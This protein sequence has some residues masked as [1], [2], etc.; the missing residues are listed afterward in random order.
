MAAKKDSKP[1]GSGESPDYPAS[2]F[3]KY[4]TGSSVSLEETYR[5]RE[6]Q[7]LERLRAATAEFSGGAYDPVQGV[8]GHSMRMSDL[9]AWK[10]KGG[11]T[12]GSDAVMRILGR[13]AYR[14]KL[15]RDAGDDAPAEITARD[16]LHAALESPDK[17][18]FEGPPSGSF[19]ELVQPFVKRQTFRAI[20]SNEM[21]RWDPPD[22]AARSEI[23]RWDAV[24][25][26]GEAA[27]LRYVTESNLQ[28]IST[29]ALVVGAFFSRAGQAALRE[30][31]VFDSGYERVRDA[32]AAAIRRMSYMDVSPWNAV[33]TELSAQPP[34]APTET[35]IRRPEYSPDVV[36]L[37][38]GDPL[39]SEEDA[40]AL[41]ELMLL[42]S[43][44]PP[45]A[46]G[47]FGAWGSGKTTLMRRIQRMVRDLT[48]DENGAAGGAGGS[49]SGLIKGVVQIEFNA[50]TFADSE[51]LW[52]SLASEI[53]DQLRAGGIDKRNG[54]EASKLVAQ[55]AARLAKE[56]ADLR[57]A[58]EAADRQNH[59]IEAARERLAAAEA[60]QNSATADAVSDALAEVVKLGR[61]D[62]KAPPEEAKRWQV[63]LPAIL[64]FWRETHGRGGLP[65]LLTAGA[66]VAAAAA[67]TFYLT[68]THLSL[69]RFSVIAAFGLAAVRA[70]LPFV[71][72]TGLVLDKR[73]ER[74]IAAR[75]AAATARGKLQEAKASQESSLAKA[76]DAEAFIS[77]FGG[78][79]TPEAA[80]SPSRLLEYLLR[81]SE[82]VAAL[83]KQL[84]FL[85]TVRGCFQHLNEVLRMMSR[86]PGD[87]H[88]ERIIVYID[89]LDRCSP[90]Q[91]VDIL[92]AIH[93]L[94]A[95]DCFVVVLAA[96]AAWLS[97]SLEHEHRH[98]LGDGSNG[99]VRTAADYLEKIIQIPFWVRPLIDSDAPDAA[100]RYRGYVQLVEHL[101]GRSDGNDRDSPGDTPP[102]R[103][104]AG[105][106]EDLQLTS[107]AHAPV[108]AFPAFPP[109]APAF[110]SHRLEAFKLTADE[111]ILFAALG[112]LAA[113]SPRAVKRMINIYRLIRVSHDRRGADAFLKGTSPD[114]A[115]FWAVQFALACE[116]GLPPEIVTLLHETVLSG[117][118]EQWRQILAVDAEDGG[119]SS[120]AP[121]EEEPHRRFLAR[122][123]ES[124]R[125]PDFNV[126]LSAVEKATGA[127]LKREELANAL[128]ES[129]RYS[130]RPA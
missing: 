64:K 1:Q 70:V 31:G 21:Q 111:R 51:N 55:I 106:A 80:R 10:T 124:R 71:A 84:G 46:I 7:A 32:V 40:R 33:A 47:L 122:L 17:I 114:I 81:E 66:A 26:L 34:V 29:R 125:R 79:V 30:L 115:P 107:R 50:W 105:L 101:F 59:E 121:M 75:S 102:V 109:S 96:D 97:H 14:A 9:E 39:G 73:R 129:R 119:T 20:P 2:A 72:F 56:A 3:S 95:F 108:E 104:D 13:A 28:Q 98:T 123:R 120:A 22:D 27:R 68:S 93:L 42:A 6:A 91:V 19:A 43:A 100:A 4:S 103:P 99:N 62:G 35:I 76:R 65:K 88:I 92:E 37:D 112:P 78:A 12:Y 36:G 61:P 8:L 11:G 53:F 58:T 54:V 5:Q 63:A 24:E 23:L 52:A 85:A 94:L 116:V 41:A 48:N 18:S 128:E 77:E 74:F 86:T 127:P 110:G 118:D 130:F 89:D 67:L 117:T 38:V 60:N 126:A 16:L 45:I 49:D 57:S 90:G 87:G 113:K 15:R 25:I 82:D 83:G 69:G 44:A